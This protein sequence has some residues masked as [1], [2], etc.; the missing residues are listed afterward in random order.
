MIKF[1]YLFFF[2]SLVFAN[3]CK[4]KLPNS[5]IYSSA[6]SLK[7][8]LQKSS[9]KFCNTD[10][11]DSLTSLL[12]EFQGTIPF[13][14][15]N[16]RATNIQVHSQRSNDIAIQIHQL[17]Q[18]LTDQLELDKNLRVAR[19]EFS[20]KSFLSGSNYSIKT[21]QGCK[22]PGDF[23]ALLTSS[24]GD[25]E[26]IKF[27]IEQKITALKV[28]QSIP[29]QSSISSQFLEAVEIFTK[30]PSKYISSMKNIS[31]F[32]TVRNLGTGT[33]LENSFVHPKKLVRFNQP[34]QVHLEGSGIT[35]RTTAIARGSG[36]YGDIIELENTQSK[37]RF[38]G[39]IIDQ[40]I[41][42]VEL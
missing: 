3:T 12:M 13:Q 20:T 33:I 35:L 21:C 30:E 37:K 24:D 36:G 31:F 10:N 5:L 22:E 32:H 27:S 39:K 29:T 16:N 28:T 7:A 1:L 11:I 18:F 9:Q 42:R 15:I 19:P 17:G 23:Q 34:T 38:M 4:V 14:V 26:W 6:D 40:N 41:V 2:T 25:K 8:F